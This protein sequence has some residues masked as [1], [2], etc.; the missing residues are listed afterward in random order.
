[1]IVYAESNFVLELALAQEQSA[2]CEELLQLAKA[3]QI[4]F[5]VPAF[6]FAEPQGTLHRRK[7]ER[8]QLELRLKDELA[9]L[10]RTPKYFEQL[11][12]FARVTA[13]LAESAEAEAANLQSVVLSLLDCAEVIPLEA[14]IVSSAIQIE[15]RHELS[16]MDAIVYASVL[17]HLQASARGISC[18]LNRNARDFE[19]PDI[20]AELGQLNCRL[21]P[22]FDDG[23]EFV[24]SQIP[25]LPTE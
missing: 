19:D 9:Q 6:C 16:A 3:K 13:V 24:K 18:F 14:M 17:A 4:Q 12:E 1:M 15:A 7:R 25:K 8:G 2:S 5:V 10:A 22:R 21:I 11:E 23:L 20:L